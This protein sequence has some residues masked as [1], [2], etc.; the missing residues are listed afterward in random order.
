MNGGISAEVATTSAVTTVLVVFGVV[1]GLLWQHYV[2]YNI[3]YIR[4]V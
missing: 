4:I 2:L 3:F 1:V